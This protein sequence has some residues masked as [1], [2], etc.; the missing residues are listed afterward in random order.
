MYCKYCGSKLKKKDKTCKNCTHEISSNDVIYKKK[1]FLVCYLLIIILLGVIGFGYIYVNKPEVI[2]N[3]VLKS[4]YEYTS[5]NYD[6]LKQVKMN[7]NFKFDITG[8]SDYEKLTK[9]INDLNI[10]TSI[11]VDFINKDI[12]FD[13]DLGYKEDSIIKLDS[14]LKEDNTY[15]DLNDLF[16]KIIMYKSDDKIEINYDLDDINLLLEYQYKAL[17]ESLKVA[18]YSSEKEDNINKN[19]LIINN[20]NIKEVMSYYTNY[21][22]SNEEYI[23]LLVKINSST[24]EDEVKSI[25]KLNDIEEI[26]EIKVI[27]YSKILTNEPIKIQFNIKNYLDI[28]YNIIDK[29][30]K[31]D[32]LNEEINSTIEVKEIDDTYIITSNTKSEDINIKITA[33]LVF[34]YNIENNK[35][36]SKTYINYE[37]IS[38][39]DSEYILDKLMEKEVVN[40]L[41]EEIT[42]IFVPEIDEDV[43]M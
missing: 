19:T 39:E 24:Y 35:P 11:N 17:K 34:S 38:E 10:N 27:I 3:S 37:E 16:D 13:L 2:F 36:S 4:V 29:A 40:N 1:N 7:Y 21:L 12:A 15:I 25:N 42:K 41:I 8:N 43:I 28:E 22:L 30:M 18:I 33:S 23:N 14:Y 26:S 20:S 9:I 32:V 6:K 31:I 5:S